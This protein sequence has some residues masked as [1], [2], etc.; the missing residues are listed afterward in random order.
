MNLAVFIILV[1]LDPIYDKLV[2]GTSLLMLILASDNGG[3]ENL[4]N[5]K[6]INTC[7]T[8]I[9]HCQIMSLLLP[10]SGKDVTKQFLVLFLRELILY[11]SSSYCQCCQCTPRMKVIRNFLFSSS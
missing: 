7:D 5:L 2:A 11:I 10:V 4:F 3:C 8:K 1:L 6:L 9:F